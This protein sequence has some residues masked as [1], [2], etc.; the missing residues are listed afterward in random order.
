MR[1]NAMLRRLTVVFLGCFALSSAVSAAEGDGL[2]TLQ[3]GI[4]LALKQSVIVHAAREGVAIAEASRM[5]A[6]TE[7]LPKFSTSY[8]YTRYNEAPYSIISGFP[9]PTSRTVVT[10]GTENN[11]TWALE[12][13]QPI[14]AGGGILANYEASKFEVSTAEMEERGAV[15]DIVRDVKIAYFNVIKAERLL[16]VA[17]QSVKQLEAHRDMAQDFFDVGM[18]PRND[19][20]HAEVQLANGRQLLIRSENSLELVRAKLNTVLRREIDTPVKVEDIFAYKPFGRSL[21]DC[22]TIAL[23]NRPEIRAYSLKVQQAKEMV[24]QAKSEFLPNVS[25]VGNYSRFGDTP[26]VS[27]NE[28]RDEESWYVMAVAN[29]NF[30]EWGKTKNR[31]DK[32]KSLENQVADAFANVK[33]IIALEVKNAYLIL[34]EAERQIL[35]SQKTIEQAEENFRITRERY[36]EQVAISTDVLDAQTLLTRAK[37]D[38]TNAIGD[39]H[40]SRAS[41][42]RAMGVGHASENRGE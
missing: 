3:G 13:R 8:N 9:T 37:S 16:A 7:F 40:I 6:L 32:S 20:L 23:E 34:H 36:R 30:W 19:L 25:L 38:H 5:E 1:P 11:Y 17:R 35:V 12:A 14:F 18:I 31:V 39:Y 21:E 15:L 22:Q 10:T 26:G 33:D 41:L 24:K 28:F 42:E 4:D 27:G 29:W 2:L